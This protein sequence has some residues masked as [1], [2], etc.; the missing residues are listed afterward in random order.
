MRP[1]LAVA[2]AL[3]AACSH[4]GEPK[5][6]IA[7]AADL[8]RAFTELAAEFKTRAGTAL[9]LELG[10][11]GLLA[12]QIEQGAPFALF[13]AAN[14]AYVDQVVAAGKCDGATIQPYARGQLVVWTPSGVTGPR[15]L[16]DLADP[17]FHKIAIA[18]P[19]HAPYGVAAQQ[20]LERAGLW[21]QLQD[22]IVLGDN[23]QATMLYARERNADAAII[24]QSLAVVTD[25]GASLAIDPAL[26]APLDQVL[27]VCGHGAEADVARRFAAFVGSP[28]GR[29]VMSRYG[30]VLPAGG[31]RP[32]PAR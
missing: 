12:K 26:H 16:A 18:N 2:L 32:S 29:E 31:V 14:R 5:V 6:R 10:S 25:G 11:S 27:V 20:A 8:A 19:A 4:P 30:F 24:A 28:D 22:R 21:A 15:A 13:A 9:E 23:V 3:S 17:R 1:A 7:A